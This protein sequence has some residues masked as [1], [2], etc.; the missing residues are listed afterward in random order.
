MA[1]ALL[2]GALGFTPAPA[3][4]NADPYVASPARADLVIPEIIWQRVLDGVGHSGKLLG[5]DADTMEHFR[6]ST[7]ILRNVEMLYRDILSVPQYTGLASDDFLNS[8]DNFANTTFLA[9]KMIDGYA[10]RLLEY[11]PL[12]DWIVQ[13]IPAGASTDE[14]FRII[15]EKNG[16]P[17]DEA[18]WAEWGKLPEEYKKI[19]VWVLIA[20]NE[21]TPY[22]VESFDEDFYKTY[23]GANDLGEITSEQLYEFAD[24]PWIEVEEDFVGVLAPAPRESFDALDKF[25]RGYFATGSNMFMQTVYGAIE[26]Y[27]L[28]SADHEINA[29]GFG[30]LEFETG[31]G[32]VAVFGEGDDRIEGDYSLVLDLGGNDTYLGSTAVPRGF[33]HP[34]GL[35]IDLGGNDTYDSGDLK[36]GLACGNHGIGAIVDLAG[37]DNYKC[38]E[39]GIA[40]AWYGTGLVVDYAGDDTY[41]S[42]I[43]GQGAAHA[44]VGMLMDMS[45]N[46]HYNCIEQSQAFGSTYGIGVLI[47]P[48]GNDIYYADPEGHVSVTFEGRTCNFAQGTGFG[49]RADFGD[50]HSL[51]GGIGMLVDGGGDD[52]YTG[53]VY[54]QGAGYWW[55]L[56][57]L[58]DRAGNDTYKC[59]QYSL[60]S[61]PHFAIGCTVDLAGDDKYNVGNEDV[62]RQIQ[63]HARDGSIAVF[64]DGSGNDEYFLPNLAAGSS[65]LNCLTIFWDRMGDDSYTAD[66]NPPSPNAYSFG[67]ITPYTPFNTFRDTMACVGIF[68]DTAGTD[69]YA[70]RPPLDGEGAADLI[71]VPFAQNLEWRQ[72]SDPYFWGF[73][74]D[75]E[76]FVGMAEPE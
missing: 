45:G 24:A 42:R 60:G 56:G 38:N 33:D 7:C 13:W 39:S 36:A 51:G 22:L 71:P 41:Y 31:M 76:W 3:Q 69:T 18:S 5:Y 40:C 21:D 35:V 58:E 74:L 50:G 72:R 27:Q 53:S 12:G 2:L 10:A 20:A 43:F 44:G 62:E 9:W 47:D 23:F 66:R 65:D 75:I 26:E 30:S 32:R 8:G 57:S 63:G 25:D 52:S 59:E 6:G 34:I 15:L 14:A 68:L 19:I 37:D 46:D 49:R 54:S 17:M 16:T 4:E 48:E 28:S 70:E 67:M 55:A 29:A 64:I 73:G 11:A 61:A 1:L